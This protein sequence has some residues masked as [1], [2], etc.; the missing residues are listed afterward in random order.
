MSKYIYL[1]KQINQTKQN[2]IYYKKIAKYFKLQKN[3]DV[4]DEHVKLFN[5][6]INHNEP[7]NNNKIKNNAS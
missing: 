4:T 1:M 3:S 2:K 6:I 7:N 5:T